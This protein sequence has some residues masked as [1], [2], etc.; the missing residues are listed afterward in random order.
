MTYNVTCYKNLFFRTKYQRL[1]FRKYSKSYTHCITLVVNYK[2]PGAILV[3]GLLDFL[4]KLSIKYGAKP[5]T[6]T[7]L[8]CQAS[9]FL[10]T[11]HTFIISQSPPPPNTHTHNTTQRSPDP[12]SNSFEVKQVPSSRIGIKEH[13]SD[14]LHSPITE[15]EV[16]QDLYGHR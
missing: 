5:V 12:R 9:D 16:V 10:D 13:K 14:R 2:K 15:K 4:F 11:C 8:S 7:K 1:Y 3:P 6:F